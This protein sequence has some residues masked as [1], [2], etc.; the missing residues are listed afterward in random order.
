[1]TNVKQKA[2]GVFLS[3]FGSAH[4]WGLEIEKPSYVKEVDTSRITEAGGEIETWIAVILAVIISIA[5]IIPGY[6][7]FNGENEKAI[8]SL[9]SIGLGAVTVVILGG[10]VFGVMSTIGG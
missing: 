1:M 10:V 9:K 8:A 7:F 4:V 2:M 6:H 5:A 3:A